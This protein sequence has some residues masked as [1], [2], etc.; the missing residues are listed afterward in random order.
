[1]QIYL[2]VFEIK[3]E[4]VLYRNPHVGLH[5]KALKPFLPH[6]ENRLAKIISSILS[7]AK[8]SPERQKFSSKKGMTAYTGMH[9][10]RSA[11]IPAIFRD[12]YKNTYLWINFKGIG[13]M[14]NGGFS[15]RKDGTVGDYM[16]L[17]SWR[18]AHRDQVLSDLLLPCGFRTS[19]VLYIVKLGR[20]PW[21][22]GKLH[23]VEELVPESRKEENTPVVMVRGMR[24]LWRLADF[25]DSGSEERKDMLE[26]TLRALKR[27]GLEIKR[28]GEY[29][30]WFASTLAK[31]LAILYEVRAR[32]SYLTLHNITLAAEIVDLDSVSSHELIKSDKKTTPD[33][34]FADVKDACNAV[35]NLAHALLIYREL[36]ED[37]LNLL[38]RTYYNAIMEKNFAK[39]DLDELKKIIDGFNW[40]KH[41]KLAREMLLAIDEGYECAEVM[42]K[43]IKKRHG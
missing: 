4:D 43:S 29:L 7:T 30:S 23:P 8:I 10:R 42:G 22:D 32:H 17:L 24:N 15:P 33:E 38:L 34:L 21:K 19:I 16:G 20:L 5:L 25:C 6:E 26:Y 2:P 9:H 13:Y 14:A 18:Y 40:A 36:V 12:S 37:A 28:S 35:Q 41:C 1:M 31:Q 39:K 27:E 3:E 11:V